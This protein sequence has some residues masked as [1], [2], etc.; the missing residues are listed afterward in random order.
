MIEA[1]FTLPVFLFVMLFG[2]ET[3]RLAF[4]TVTLQHAANRGVR[5]ASLLIA[6]GGGITR[7]QD[8]KQRII[9][10]SVGVPVQTGNIHICP[11]TNLSCGGSS[12]GVAGE[13]IAIRVNQPFS[14]LGG[15]F[16]LP[17]AVTAVAK[18]E[19]FEFA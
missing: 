2:V 16:T 11:V 15:L 9:D 13:T 1:T 12:P 17:I 4:T 18:N 7:A 19:P 14:F 6:P 5:Y 10:Y 8:I 3:M